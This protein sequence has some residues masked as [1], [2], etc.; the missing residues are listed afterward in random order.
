MFNIKFSKRHT[1]QGG[2]CY[3]K[4][5]SMANFRLQFMDTSSLIEK[6]SWFVTKGLAYVYAKFLPYVYLYIQTVEVDI[7][8]TSLWAG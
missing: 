1:R 8:I 2:L 3:S 4:I 5:T 7:L 6:N